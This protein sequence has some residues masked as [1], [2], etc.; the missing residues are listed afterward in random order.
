M[1]RSPESAARARERGRLYGPGWA[2]FSSRIR[3]ERAGGCCECVGTCGLHRTTPGPRR[4]VERHGEPARFAR[5]KVVLTVAHLCHDPRC[6][7]EDHVQA[8]IKKEEQ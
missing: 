6:R 1:S 7:R 3:F 5:G 8:G 2:E 4:C